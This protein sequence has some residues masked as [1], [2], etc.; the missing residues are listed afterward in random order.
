MFIEMRIGIEMNIGLKSMFTEMN[1]DL[2]SMFIEMRIGRKM[3][4][5]RKICL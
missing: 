2:K 1:I 4:I 3:N 5:G